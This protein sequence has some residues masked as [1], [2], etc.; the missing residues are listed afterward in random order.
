VY[1]VERCLQGAPITVE[2]SPVDQYG[3]PSDTDP[4]TVTVAVTRADGTVLVAAGAA[5]DGAGVAPRTFTITAAQTGAQLDQLEVAWS[6]VA[7][8]VVHRTLVDIVGGVYCS[9]AEVRD[10]LTGKDKDRFTAGA[11]HQ[12]RVEVEGL[13]ERACGH[14]VSFVPRFSVYQFPT[15]ADSGL[16]VPHLFLRRVRWVSYR[17]TVGAVVPVDISGGVLI[18][19]SGTVAL[20][21]TT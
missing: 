15:Y 5:T 11:V 12:A 3:D 2:W 13:I 17:S 20:H 4:G 10:P 19:P 16:T 21:H 14:A 8:G 7:A 9:L 1:S 18:E 6:T